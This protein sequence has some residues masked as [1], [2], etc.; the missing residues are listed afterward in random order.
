MP[1]ALAALSAALLGAGDFFA[2]LGGR[3]DGRGAAAG[4]TT[5]WVASISGAIASWLLLIVV[6][7]DQL[8]AADLWWSLAAGA[9]V[10]AARPLLYIGMARGPMAVDE[11]VQVYRLISL[12]HLTKGDLEPA[13]QT[14]RDLLRTAPTYQADP[15]QDP[16]SYVTM[17][18]VVRQEMAAA[19]QPA[20]ATTSNAGT[21]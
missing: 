1:V 8:T 14:V 5:A 21:V 10:S 20:R 3:R 19:A 13:Q 15:I 6:R 11:A 9:T 12:S 7:P 16:P 2:G 17:V 18:D 4:L